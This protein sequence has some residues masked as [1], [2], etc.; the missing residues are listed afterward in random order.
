V[1]NTVDVRKATYTNDIGAGELKALWTD[2]DHKPGEEAVFYVRVLE[3]PTPRWS[4][5]D[6]VK[7]GVPPPETVPATLQE[8]AWSS[9][10]WI[11][12]TQ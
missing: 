12:K 10:V 7:L 8:R 2:P 4:T 11:T 5:F 3:I 1:G 9:P 6:A